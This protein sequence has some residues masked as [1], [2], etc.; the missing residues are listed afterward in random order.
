MS[1]KPGIKGNAETVVVHEN[2]AAAV[3][4]G[5]VPVFSTPAMIALMESSAVSALTP[6]LSEGEGSVGTFLHVT[7]DAATPIGFRVWA[8]CELTAVEGRSL[9]FSVTAYD[10]QGPIGKGTHGRAIINLERFLAR[11]E[12]KKKSK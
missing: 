11:V 5:L 8:E 4:S 9:T 2:T 1:L 7:H 6:W 12:Q 3:G 10:E